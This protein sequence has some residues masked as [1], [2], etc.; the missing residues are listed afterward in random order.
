MLMTGGSFKDLN[1][2]ALLDV[3][4]DQTIVPM[5]IKPLEKLAQMV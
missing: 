3:F 1:P 2:K 5:F 4:V